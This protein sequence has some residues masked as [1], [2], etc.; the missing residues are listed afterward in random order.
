MGDNWHAELAGSP[1]PLIEFWLA[2]HRQIARAA[3]AQIREFEADRQVNPPCRMCRVV[4]VGSAQP[5]P[6]QED[7]AGSVRVPEPRDHRVPAPCPGRNGTYSLR[8]HRPLTRPA[9]KR[10]PARQG[11]YLT[12][13]ARAVF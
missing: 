3:Q 13:N 9:T 10:E 12:D 5:Q 7:R 6:D 11:R 4:G 2:R 1:R 8:L